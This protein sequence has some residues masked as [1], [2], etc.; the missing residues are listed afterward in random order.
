M[1]T[2]QCNLMTQVVEEQIGCVSFSGRNRKMFRASR[3][4]ICHLDLVVFSVFT[5]GA[6]VNVSLCLAVTQR[7][8]LAEEEHKV[9]G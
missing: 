7:L 4:E 3:G 5:L 9:L 6:Y 1:L 2:S 8:Y